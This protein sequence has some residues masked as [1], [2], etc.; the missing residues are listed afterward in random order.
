MRLEPRVWKRGCTVMG[1][2]KL[3][4]IV[5]REYF[6]RVRSRWF[7]LATLL[8]PIFLVF[9]LFLPVIMGERERR[10]ESGTIRILDATSDSVGLLVARTLRGGVSGDTARAQWIPVSSDSQHRTAEDAA[11]QA[12]RTGAIAGYLLLDAQSIERGRL[13]YAGRNTSALL[14]MQALEDAITRA[15]LTRQLEGEGIGARRSGALADLQ[16]HLDTERLTERGRSGSGRVSVLVAI[17]VAVTLYLTIFMHGSNVM[18]GVLEE[19]QT[20]VAE[21]VLSSVSSDTLL[22]GKVLGIGAVGLT[23]LVT[24]TTMSVALL[25][26]RA[27]VLARFGLQVEAFALPEITGGL[28]VIILLSFLLGFLFY[29]AL[30][31]AVGAM[32]STEQ[33]AQ[34]A[35]LPVVLLLVLSLAM[36][37]GVITN[38]EGSLATIMTLLPMSSPIVLPLRLSLS[39]VPVAESISALVI[40]LLSGIAAT[41]VASRLYRTGVLMYGKRATLREAWRWMWRR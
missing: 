10:S 12:V 17:G 40:L 23:Q 2:S 5:G 11:V 30:F 26:I 1:D 36:V 29:A 39:P 3:A 28:A 20:R 22:I 32:V 18:R 8:A 13:R 27:P 34:Q 9:L 21:V 38:P 7:L 24:W 16:L 4:T 19:K 37:Q 15:V 33:D 31:G 35:Q 14:T 25:A 6:E 41:L